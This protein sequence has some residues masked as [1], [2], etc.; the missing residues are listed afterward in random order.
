MG[1]PSRA[2]APTNDQG[3]NPSPHTERAGALA[4]PER[5]GR[6]AALADVDR[7][8]DDRRRRL[9]EAV[10]VGAHLEVDVDAEL[11]RVVREQV[12]EGL[13]LGVVL[14]RPR[15]RRGVALERV[16]QR[17]QVRLVLVAQQPRASS[18]F[19]GGSPFANGAMRPGPSRPAAAPRGPRRGSA[20]GAAPPGTRR[21][22]TCSPRGPRGGGGSARPATPSRPPA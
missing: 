2:G 16:G 5:V 8:V 15:A 7:P 6:A 19:D 18:S 12:R 9:E 3:R 14:E 10:A 17:A 11:G 13:L 20:A 1:T 22:A 21:S 4:A